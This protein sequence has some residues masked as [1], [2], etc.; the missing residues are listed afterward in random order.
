M[1][2]GGMFMEQQTIEEPQVLP[3]T[4]PAT[5]ERFGQVRAAA[6]EDIWRAMHEMRSAAPEWAS[7]SVRERATIL[8]KYQKLMLDSL[9]EITAVLN[10]DTGK[11]RQDA[12]VEVMMTVDLLEQYR[13]HAP[14]WL[15]SEKIPRGLYLFKRF[16]T[17]QRPYGVVL[18]ISPWNYPF[19]LALPPVL[20]ALLAGNTVI[21]KPSEITAASGVMI[22]RLFQRVP[23][24]SPYIRVLHGDGRVGAELIQ[25]KPDYIFL[26]GSPQT[27]K[28]VMQAA[29]ENFT[30]VACELGGKDAVIILEDAD[31]PSAAHW[32]V[33]GAYYNTGQTCMSVER[34][35][36]VEQVYDEFVRNA[37]M[38]TQKLNIGYTKDRESPYYMGPMTDP[39]QIKIID[40]Q[41][42]D[43]QAKGARI[44]TGG[45]RRGMFIE[46]MVIVDVNHRMSLMVE[47]TFGP[48]IPIVKVKDEAEAIRLANDSVY[49]LGASVWGKDLRR[50]ERVA[51][52]IQAGSI[53]INDAITQIAVPMLPFGGQKQSGYGRIHGKEGMVQFTQTYSYAVGNVPYSFDLA[54]I[55]RTPGHYWLG[56]GLWRL[57]FGTTLAQRWLGLK[58][59]LGGWR[60]KGSGRNG[61]D[62]RASMGDAKNLSEN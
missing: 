41:L 2:I 27:G 39:R 60:K 14:H 45:E 62:L 18:V 40:R 57:V 1:G 33:W 34:V 30:P 53:L 37:V 49:G 9:D 43:A 46:P 28:K 4:N 31:I 54:V 23:E 13:K 15:R 48:I 38:E 51:H 11:S 25:L 3:F 19:Y 58:E 42:E 12:L 52:Q 29:A 26:T 17:L 32:C 36:A 61:T 21:L 44:L 47:E 20:A 55:M 35:Y 59:I 24:L 5:G 22:E 56:A 7:K 16:Y 50:A 8:K 6:P 10:Q